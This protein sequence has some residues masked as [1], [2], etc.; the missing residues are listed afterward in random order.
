MNMAAEV[1]NCRLFSSHGLCPR[2]FSVFGNGFSHE[3]AVAANNG[4]GIALNSA[5]AVDR[6][7]YPVVAC[8][9]GKVLEAVLFLDISPKSSL[10]YVTKINALVF[11]DSDTCQHCADCQGSARCTA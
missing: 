10:T 1:Y 8:R 2:V 3:S 5:L 11:F 9:Y 7:I 6:S 4:S